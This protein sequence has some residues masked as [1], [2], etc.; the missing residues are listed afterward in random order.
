[1]QES[2]QVHRQSLV[3]GKVVWALMNSVFLLNG[4]LMSG[5]VKSA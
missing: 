4:S 1:M 5:Q 3:L 2:L